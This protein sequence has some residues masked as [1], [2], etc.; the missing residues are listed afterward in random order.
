MVEL[1]IDLISWSTTLVFGR[2]LISE[3]IWLSI[4]FYA[5]LCAWNL[6]VVVCT[7]FLSFAWN[8]DCKCRVTKINVTTMW[9]VGLEE[10]ILVSILNHTRYPYIVSSR[11]CTRVFLQ[12]GMKNIS[13][14]EDFH[15]EMYILL[16]LLVFWPCGRG[17]K[18]GNK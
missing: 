6:L 7:C 10:I 3:Y 1:L 8:C 15:V 16:I 18:V 2:Q 13:D 17:A 12:I 5:F 4:Q 14:R 9:G 11:R